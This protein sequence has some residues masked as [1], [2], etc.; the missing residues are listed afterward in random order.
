MSVFVG[1]CKKAISLL[2]CAGKY[3]D[4]IYCQHD[5]NRESLYLPLRSECLVLVLL[6][7]QMINFQSILNF[8]QTFHCND[9]CIRIYLFVRLY[10]KMMLNIRSSEILDFSNLIKGRLCR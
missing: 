1:L 5:A 7:E 6:S 3:C 8:R 2:A 4:S 9:F 10:E